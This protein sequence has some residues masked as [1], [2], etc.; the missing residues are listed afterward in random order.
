MTDTQWIALL[1][2]LAFILSLFAVCISIVALIAVFQ[3][4]GR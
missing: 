1:M 4:K 2:V 3:N